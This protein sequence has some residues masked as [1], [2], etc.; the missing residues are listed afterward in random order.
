LRDTLLRILVLSGCFT[1]ILTESLSPFHLLRRGPLAIGWIAAAALCILWLRGHLARPKFS[2][3]PVESAIAAALL[4]IA[5]PVGM[6]AALSP[7]NSTDA[8]AY[9]LPRV[10]YWAQA[11]SASFSPPLI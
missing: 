10:I 1:A 5:L 8:M 2:W 6:A 9:H 7:P 3:H 11:G 4:A